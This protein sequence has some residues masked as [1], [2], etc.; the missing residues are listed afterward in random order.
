LKNPDDTHVLVIG[1]AASQSLTGL[2]N[3]L[4]C[5]L[6]RRPALFGD[7]EATIRNV[8]NPATTEEIIADDFYSLRVVFD[9]RL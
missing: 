6:V 4:H 8:A 2:G 3:P 1:D 9:E 7:L 5:C